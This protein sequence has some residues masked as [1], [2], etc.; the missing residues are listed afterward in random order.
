MS[1]I[2]AII[3]DLNG[4][5]VQAPLLSDRLEKDFSLPH[6]EFLPVLKKI[7]DQVRQPNAP[8]AYQL[9]KPYLEKW[10]IDLT[11]EEFIDYWFSAEQGNQ[12]LIEIARAQ[13]QK[14]LRLFVYSNNFKERSNHYFIHL[15]FLA[16]LFEQVY[17]SWQIGYVKPSAAGLLHICQEINL[18]PNEGLAIDDSKKNIET[19]RSIGMRGFVFKD[20]A[21]VR[22]Y[23]NKL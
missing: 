7:M 10:K 18:D 17:Y 19:A 9:F 22:E 23:L 12:E 13:K 2:K 11:K 3:F 15:P 20:A 4:V 21:Q 6:G 5:F 16:E 14:G 8:K 1:G